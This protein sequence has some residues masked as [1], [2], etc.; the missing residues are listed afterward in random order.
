ML[1]CTRWIFRVIDMHTHIYFMYVDFTQISNQWPLGGLACLHGSRWND[2]AKLG[3]GTES[4]GTVG[5]LLLCPPPLRANG[6]LRLFISLWSDRD[7]CDSS[8]LLPDAAPP[9]SRPGQEH[10]PWPPLASTPQLLCNLTD[11]TLLEPSAAKRM[12]T[13]WS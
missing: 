9:R 12:A 3:Q 11:S 4:S 13:S 10:R 8:S 7:V 5:A 6:I 2:S 1:R